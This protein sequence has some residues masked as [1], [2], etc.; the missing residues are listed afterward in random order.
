MQAINGNNIT[1]ARGDTLAFTVT[2]TKDGLPY[3]PQ[4]D[5]VIRFAISLGYEGEIGYRLMFT[6]VIDNEL[7]TVKMT[8]EE[9]KMLPSFRS[10][11]YD[12][13]ITFADGVVDTFISGKLF[14]TGEV[15]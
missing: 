14:V 7:L 9:T 3:T 4:D 12:V 13:Q 11:N 15:A 5:D 1:I 10:Y 8:S 6:K 2:V